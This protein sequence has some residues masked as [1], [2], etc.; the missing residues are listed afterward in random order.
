MRRGL[1]AFTIVGRGDAAVRES[2]ERV[3]T[4][5]INAGFDFPQRR[6]TVNLAPAH[7]RKVG[8]GFDLA[9]ACGVL[10]ASEQLPAAEL[11]RWAVFGE[12]SLGGEL[13]H[14]RG[15][16][17]VA[18]GAREAGIAGLIV[19][20]ECAREAALVD[21]LA[22]AGVTRL[23]EVAAILR[24]EP[25]PM[26]PRA[27]RATRRARRRRGPRRRARPLRRDPRADD[28]GRGR[29]QPPAVRP[30]RHRQD[31]ARSAGD[32]DPP[33]ADAR[34]GDHRDAH[35]QHR[36]PTDRRRARPRA[37]VPSPAS[38]DLARRTRRRRLRAAARRGDARASRGPVPRRA[39]GVQ[40][41]RAGG[42]AP[43][44][45]GRRRDDRARPV[46]RAVSDAV[47]AARLDEPMPVRVRGR[48]ALPLHGGRRRAPPPQAQR[49]AAR[50][51]RPADRHAAARR[52][53]TRARGRHSLHEAAWGG[54]RCPR[55]SGTSAG[56]HGV[57]DERR[58]HAPPRA[59]ARAGGQRRHE[60][61]APGVR[62][63][64]RSARA[65]T[66]AS[67]AWRERLPTSTPA[68]AC[69]PRTSTRRSVCGARGHSTA[70]WRHDCLRRLPASHRARR[71]PRAAR[72][73]HA[74][75]TA[76][77]PQAARA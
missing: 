17:S 67:C 18:E 41:R 11:E 50:P 14:C 7:L 59:R 65:G 25:P 66:D 6:I 8:P 63:K 53:R 9:T 37:A 70:R 46:R 22:V 40:P 4:A 1:P 20:R 47:S 61:A 32:L 54:P 13:R 77:A 44:A 49:S 75:R 68:R 48:Q 43:T 31:D 12:L 34:R 57:D 27:G 5:L 69:A 29:A 26:L 16:L 76:Q 36:R 55:A 2:R 52:R 3:Q 58:A 64:A 21:G 15:V 74:A 42:A 56:G 38:H 71:P 39:V 51:Y 35:P 30:A 10:V 73:T 23:D 72:R 24:G 62:A 45:R 60:G 19:P 33:A 28:R